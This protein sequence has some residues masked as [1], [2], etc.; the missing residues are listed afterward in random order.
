MQDIDFDE[1]DRAVSSVS[2][3]SPTPP[4]PVFSAP[5]PIS[6]ATPVTRAPIEDQALAAALAGPE[7]ASPAVRRSTGRFM[8]VVHS[9]SDM[10][11]ARPGAPS[12]SPRQEAVREEVTR[13]VVP[14]RSELTPNTSAAFQWPDPIDH[15]ESSAAP[16]VEVPAPIELPSAPIVAEP[17][18]SPLE[19]PFLA[20]AKVEKR[21]LG[22]FSGPD[23][24]I[25]LLED[26]P[27]PTNTTTEVAVPEPETEEVGIPAELNDDILALETPHIDEL[28]ETPTPVIETPAPVVDDIPVGPTS[29][30][31]QYKEQASSTAEQSGSIFDTEAYHQPIAQPAKKRSAL[32]VVVWLLALVVV[33][34][35]IGAAI[36]FV[37]I[38]M[39]S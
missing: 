37:V 6:P 28:P 18:A 12:I 33:G 25:P 26:F 35:G 30:T 38:P 14:E 19:S 27:A 9:S 8:D 39:I 4:N 32:L 7:A 23:S 13:D 15:H 10:R 3:T 16:V 36:Y 29:I 34:G 24:D 2:N 1:I 20:D 11:P 22:A 31:Q 21:P 17:V 5:A